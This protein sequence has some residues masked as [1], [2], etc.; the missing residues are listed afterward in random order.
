MWCH[1]LSLERMVGYRCGSLLV[2][3]PPPACLRTQLRRVSPRGTAYW[4]CRCDCGQHVVRSEFYLTGPGVC[5]ASC[6]CTYRTGSV[7]RSNEYHR[8][9]RMIKNRDCECVSCGCEHSLCA[10]HIESWCTA[11]VLRYDK[12]NGITLCR[13]CHKAV[14]SMYGLR[15]TR[16]DLDEF[17]AAK[18]P[19]VLSVVGND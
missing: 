4:M 15:T 1:G 13:A 12:D 10:H 2:V 7:P 19:D 16:D 9:A 11:P 17:L 5:N 3:G 18:D 8:W 6:G 14:H